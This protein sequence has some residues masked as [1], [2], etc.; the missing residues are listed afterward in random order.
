MCEGYQNRQNI[1]TQL[2][3]HGDFKECHVIIKVKPDEYHI[4]NDGK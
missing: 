2:Y 3:A 1:N 4:E